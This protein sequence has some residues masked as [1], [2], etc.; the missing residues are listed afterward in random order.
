MFSF[1]SLFTVGVSLFTAGVFTL[2]GYAFKRLF[3]LLLL[4]F[5][6]IIIAWFFFPF[7]PMMAQVFIT[8]IFS[9]TY[10]LWLVL[11]KRKVN[12]HIIAGYSLVAAIICCGYLS[13][14]LQDRLNTLYQLRKEHP[15]A[16]LVSRLDYEKSSSNNAEQNAVT[17]ELDSK[18]ENRMLAHEEEEEQ[19][20]P[21]SRIRVLKMLHEQ[22]QEEF[23]TA[24]GFGIV[25][26]FRVRVTKEN[27]ILPEN[28]PELLPSLPANYPKEKFPYNPLATS[29]LLL[30]KKSKLSNSQSSSL[31]SLTQI[32]FNGKDDF[33]A[34]EKNGYVK[35]R[36]YVVD[37]QG[38]HLTRVPSYPLE[39]R[40][41]GDKKDNIDNWVIY[42]NWKI[43]QLQLVS[44]LKHQQP[45][46]YSTSVLPNL[47][48]LKDVKTRPLDSF[49]KRALEK[50]YREEDVVI[51]SGTD[52]IQMM[53]SL[54]AS[55]DCL[56]CHS[57]KRGAL[58]G[59]FSYRLFHL[60]P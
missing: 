39:Q 51:N 20:S 19:S 57:V 60:K 11:S 10:L 23:V 14:R 36:N 15:V 26:T 45:V 58:L 34:P 52:H 47:E 24:L 2:L 55:K 28:V 35:N 9:I 50:L 6:I 43:Y 44:L 37:F 56:T 40:R 46:V 21:Q 49:E 30:N 59:A 22:A 3:S 27:L 18:L 16:S 41:T 12:P 38:H 8:F 53:G 17:V 5:A 48:D 13:Y 33:L 1:L 42:Q 31:I 29:G 4:S 32:H 54:R 7:F 25:R